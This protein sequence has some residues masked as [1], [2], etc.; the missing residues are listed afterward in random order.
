LSIANRLVA[1]AGVQPWRMAVADYL[2]AARADGPVLEGRRVEAC[3]D[4][5]LAEVMERH[6]VGVHEEAVLPDL[7]VELG[8]DQQTAPQP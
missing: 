7:L 8:S 4:P 2:S 6:G 5:A 3:W 1:Q